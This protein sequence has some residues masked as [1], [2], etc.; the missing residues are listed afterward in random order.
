MPFPALKKNGVYISN[1]FHLNHKR[2]ISELIP[3]DIIKG[4]NIY[5]HTHK[6][7]STSKK[8]KIYTHTQCFSSNQVKNEL[9]N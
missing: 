6:Y 2:K 9:Q 7:Q 3:I 8:E 5:T 4:K 1:V